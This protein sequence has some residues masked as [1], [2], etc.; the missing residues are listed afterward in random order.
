M[1]FSIYK[2]EIFV[3]VVLFVITDA[4]CIH[5]LNERV[6]P[7][8]WET[9]GCYVAPNASAFPLQLRVYW[10]N[11]TE[12]VM[13]PSSCF[14]ECSFQLWEGR[15]F[16]LSVNGGCH[17]GTMLLISPSVDKSKCSTICLDSPLEFC[18][19]VNAML[20]FEIKTLPRLPA[21]VIG[22][23]MQTNNQRVF[24]FE[25]KLSCQFFM[26]HARCATYCLRVKRT[27][28]FGLIN[29]SYCYCG[30]SF[31]STLARLPFSLCYHPCTNYDL[32]LCGGEHAMLVLE[33]FQ[34]RV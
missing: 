28:M 20:V 21:R 9:F 26:S 17:C 32:D 18:G 14:E 2:P 34:I 12:L 8:L 1:A 25:E 6:Y 11:H 30:N 31:V 22:C 7:T 24:N 33:L 23:F 5:A 4:M 29:R 27:Q 10:P 19:G 3:L 13:S 15:Y 16:G